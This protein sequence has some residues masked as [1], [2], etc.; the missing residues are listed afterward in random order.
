MMEEEG[1]ERRR[2]DPVIH[3]NT[4]INTPRYQIRRIIIK[5]KSN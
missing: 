3:I 2:D 4:G 1:R 5:K